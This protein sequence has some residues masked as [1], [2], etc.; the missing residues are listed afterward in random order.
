MREIQGK[1]REVAAAT[2]RAAGAHCGKALAPAKEGQRNGI[3]R[4]DGEGGRDTRHQA[5]RSGI[6][7]LDGVDGPQRPAVGVG[8]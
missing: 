8:R 4:H 2:C 3:S 6:G 5:V 7:R 1:R